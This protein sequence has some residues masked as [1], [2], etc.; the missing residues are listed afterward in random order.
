MRWILL[1][2]LLNIFTISKS[3][4]CPNVIAYDNIE[5]YTWAGSW[6]G[7][8][9]NNGYFNNAS[10]STSN[11]A[12]VYG[13]GAG[14]STIEQDWYVL[15]NITNL[16]PS[17]TYEFKMRLGS[18]VFSNP[19]AT[20]RGVDG[21][22]LVEVQVSTD[23]EISY[24]SE[25]RITGNN[26]ATWDYNT[27]GVINKTASGVLTTYAPAGGG[28]R[29]TTGDGYSDITL[30]LT[31][32]SQLAIDILCRVNA[33]GEEWWLDNIQLIEIAPCNPLPIELVEFSGYNNEN[34]NTLTWVTATEFNNHYF[35]LERSIEGI[36]WKVITTK[37]G[38]GT[39]ST[40]N[41]YNYK[42]YSFKK[43]FI[44]YYRLSQTD[45]NGQKEYFKIIEIESKDDI[46]CEN[47]IYYT[48]SGVEIKYEEAPPGLY[49]RKC[50]N[51]IE[52]IIKIE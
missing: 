35:T 1:F 22:D 49:L 29:T 41:Y 6:F 24:T 19:T 25:I 51:K 4:N 36:D 28:N 20:S 30:T 38:A 27:V 5:T 16:N 40:P 11:S 33:N 10:V 43:G 21:A 39:V 46:K 32:I 26:N 14:S 18:Y 44:N 31:G 7:N 3:Q 37:E 52:K 17:Y 45:F 47:Y 9:L 48:L 50:G 12:V 15:P 8:T 34:Y 23:G 13:A 42:D 2:T